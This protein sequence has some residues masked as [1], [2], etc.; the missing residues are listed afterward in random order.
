M[1]NKMA[2]LIC[3][4]VGEVLH[5]S[6]MSG[7]GQMGKPTVPLRVRA[8]WWRWKFTVE[9]IHYRTLPEKT[10]STKDVP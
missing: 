1:G 6:M 9:H 3:D 4:I 10:C 5:I 7:L 8:P 2:S